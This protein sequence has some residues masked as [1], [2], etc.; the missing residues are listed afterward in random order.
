MLSK[1]VA[2]FARLRATT[3]AWC[4]QR[5]LEVVAEFAFAIVQFTGGPIVDGE[6]N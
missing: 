2:F 3:L 1:A 4:A 6:S 5:L